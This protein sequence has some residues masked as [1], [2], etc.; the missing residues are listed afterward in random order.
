[1][2]S[3]DLPVD[4]LLVARDDALID[5][6]AASAVAAGA[7]LT[8]VREIADAMD[9]WAEARLVLIA[10]ES[11]EGV[12][13]TCPRRN[14][15]FLL[16]RVSGDA[17][18]WSAALGATV[19]ILPEAAD[20]L[21]VALRGSEAGGRAVA[22]LGGS[23]GLGT[24]TLAT[25]LASAF[26]ESSA[27]VLVDADSVSGGIDLVLG[28]ERAA[29]WRWGDLTQ[30]RGHIGSLAGQLPKHGELSVLSMGR[31]QPTLPGRPAVSAVL[32]SL[33]T[34]CDQVVIDAA[35]GEFSLPEVTRFADVAML[36]VGADVRSVAGASVVL[37]RWRAAGGVPPGLVI[38]CRS[39]R[40]SLSDSRA[41]ARLLDLPM[42]VQL[43]QLREVPNAAVAGLPPPIRRRG[44]GKV[45][46][47]LIE[48]INHADS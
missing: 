29:G 7:R 3:S 41:I 21:S 25:A 9:H 28:M 27:T 48:R 2:R 26:A 13:T 4:A 37:S 19:L 35:R 1:M 43:P 33:A 42:W 39:R 47:Q 32:D 36:V 31:Q 10:A 38:R 5:E 44:L 30:A 11:A 45:T 17:A 22:V 15:V 6:V 20:W 40:P 34:A 8:I 23:G 46:R 12:A 18:K 24:S 14:K 16:G